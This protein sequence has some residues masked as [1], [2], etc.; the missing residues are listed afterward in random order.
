MNT[1]KRITNSRQEIH[2]A[3]FINHH[4][5]GLYIPAIIHIVTGRLKLRVVTAPHFTCG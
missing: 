2:F 4:I 5:L 3:V 1:G